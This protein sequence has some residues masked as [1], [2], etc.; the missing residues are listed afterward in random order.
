LRCANQR[1]TVDRYEYYSKWYH[2][3]IRELISFVDFKSDYARL[4]AMLIPAVSAREAKESVNLLV[5]LGF[6]VP[7]DSGKFVQTNSLIFSKPEAGNLFEIERFQIEMLNI[8]RGSFDALPAKK[9]MSTSTTFSIS[10]KTFD[11]FKLRIRELQQNLMEMAKID[12]V[13]QQVF[14]MTINL[15][16]VSKDETDVA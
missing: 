7:S 15:F 16:P 12:P 9:R 6:V 11:L 2:S 3:V 13:Q 4:G 10:T 5:R 1:V 14:Q 8:A